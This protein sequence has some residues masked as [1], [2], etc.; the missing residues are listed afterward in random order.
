MMESTSILIF[1]PAFEN[2]FL[3]HSSDLR[4]ANPQDKV[5]NSDRETGF[6]QRHTPPPPPTIIIHEYD[7]PDNG[8]D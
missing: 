1:P 5:C 3:P 4:S 6:L 7:P 8:L 2:K